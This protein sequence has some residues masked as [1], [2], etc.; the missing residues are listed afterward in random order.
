M[1]IATVINPS[2]NNSRR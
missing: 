2:A 1:D